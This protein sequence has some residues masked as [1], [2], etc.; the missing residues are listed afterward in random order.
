M[1]WQVPYKVNYIL[2]LDITELW[3]KGFLKTIDVYVYENNNY[4]FSESLFV[5]TTY[6]NIMITTKNYTTGQGIR[7][8]S[9]RNIFP[10]YPTTAWYYV[11][12][13]PC[14]NYT[15]TMLN[16]LLKYYPISEKPL[17]FSVTDINSWHMIG[18]V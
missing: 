17:Y 2:P 9:T 18:R 7:L 3:M 4:T 16:T 11:Y 8:W 12:T 15:F 14:Y 1:I 5:N 10:D 6:K 13:I